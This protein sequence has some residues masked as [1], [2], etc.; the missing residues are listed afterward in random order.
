MSHFIDNYIKPPLKTINE[1][2]TSNLN[3]IK[4]TWDNDKIVIQGD[5][6]KYEIDRGEELS[7]D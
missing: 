6:K 3:S 2:D 7:D 5:T 4:L 1:F